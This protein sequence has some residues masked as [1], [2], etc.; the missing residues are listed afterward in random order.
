MAL[1]NYTELQASIA[2]FLN[3]SDLTLVIPD[4]ITMAE[5]DMNRTLRIK[6]MSVRTRAPLS[7]QY[8]KL[9]PDF[10]GV[11]NIELMTDPVTPL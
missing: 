6:D 1:G 11:R 2:D 8:L 4:F 10:L 3:R 5:A 9:P 7:G